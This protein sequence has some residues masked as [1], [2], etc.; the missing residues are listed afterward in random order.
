MKQESV[1]V[2]GMTCQHCVQTITE[3]LK[4]IPGLDSV[5]VD[6]DKK[7]VDV[8]FDENETSL[9]EI[10]GKIVEVGFELPKN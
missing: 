10:T 4:K 5:A 7:E 2:E 9:Q 1:K 3:A 6:L 8:K